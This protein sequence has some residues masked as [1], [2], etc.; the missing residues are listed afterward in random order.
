MTIG[1]ITP[2]TAPGV[3]DDARWLDA[4]TADASLKMTILGAPPGAKLRTS[5][6]ASSR[7]KIHK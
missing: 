2:T 6:V 1:P 4:Y 3:T 7:P 5:G